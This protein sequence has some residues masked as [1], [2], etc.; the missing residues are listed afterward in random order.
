MCTVATDGAGA[1]RAPDAGTQAPYALETDGLT[2]FYGDI[3]GVEELTLS[4]R[5][6]ELFGLLGPNGAGKTTLIRLLLGL[7]RPTAG[8]A[9]VLGAAVDDREAFQAARG[10]V[11]Y[12]PSDTALYDELTGRRVLDY[13]G[14]LTGAS[15]RDELL[16]LFPVP[17]DRPVRTYSRGNRQKLAIVQA[18]MH[19]P[20]LVVMDEPTSG[21]DPLVQSTFAEFLRR[22]RDR[23]MTVVFS[24][25]VLGEVRDLCERVAIVRNGRLVA[26]ED[27]DTLLARSGKVVRVVTAEPVELEA[28]GFEGVIDAAVEDDGALRLVVSDNYDA[29][30]DALGSYSIRDLDVTETAIEDV[31]MHF[32]E[33]PESD[34]S[35]GDGD[36]DSDGTDGDGPERDG[37]ARRGGPLAA[38]RR[39]LLGRDATPSDHRDEGSDARPD[40]RPSRATGPGAD[41]RAIDPEVHGQ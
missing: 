35:D 33:G 15:R 19:D 28:F 31:F 10:R 4:V 1:E 3:R 30:V 38:L 22:E 6:G 21:L 13:F 40:T 7:L 37:P 39:R 17:L 25:H 20:E 24:T 23:G 34:D 12:L 26:V 14:A 9:R 2:K 36:G 5:R 16:E 18:F 11:G 29:L 27:I 8:S 41:D 32:Y